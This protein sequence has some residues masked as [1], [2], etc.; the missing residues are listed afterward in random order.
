MFRPFLFY[1]ENKLTSLLI[2][3]LNNPIMLSANLRNEYRVVSG[4]CLYIIPLFY[5]WDLSTLTLIAIILMA[6]SGAANM[7]ESVSFLIKPSSSPSHYSGPALVSVYDESS[8][9]SAFHTVSHYGTSLSQSLSKF[10]ALSNPHS[11]YLKQFIMILNI[12]PKPQK[13]QGHNVFKNH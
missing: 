9:L 4:S 7:F 5:F 6:C 10:F 8:F 11:L 1:T 13:S 2:D 3:S 12:T